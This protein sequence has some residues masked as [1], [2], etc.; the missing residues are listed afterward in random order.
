MQTN[1]VKPI[2]PEE[3]QILKNARQ[4]FL[5]TRS[6]FLRRAG[7]S[8]DAAIEKLQSNSVFDILIER[9]LSEIAY[10]DGPINA[11]EAN[12]LNVLLGKE[13]S[14]DYY[15]SL[16]R[17]PETRTFDATQSFAALI[18]L[19][20][21][22]GGV[23]QGA[24]YEAK[25]DPVV[26]CFEILGH[27]ILAADG[28]INQL[29]LDRLSKYTAI[30]HSK[31]AE[32]Y[33]RINS[34]TDE[35]TENLDPPKE[36]DKSVNAAD[37]IA[38]TSKTE[39]PENDTDSASDAVQK[40]IA[41]LHA[42][43]GLAAVKGEVETLTNL[44]KV[45]SIRKQRCLPVP[46]ISFHMVF[47]GNPGTGKT[48]VARIVAKIYGGLG[49]LSK[50]QLIEVDRSGLV[51]NFTG[52]TATKTKKVIDSAKGGVL[53]IDEAYALTKD[54]GT[55]N[56]FGPEA[57]E[58]IL[59]SMEDC[60]EDLVVIAAG[61]TDRMSTF[62][63]SNPGLR[64]RFPRVV[65]FP[66]YSVPEL[67]E[68]FRREA[69]RNQYRI[70]GGAMSALKEAVTGLWRSRGPDFANAREVRN[71][72]EHVVAMQANRISQSARITTGMLTTIMEADIRGCLLP[73]PRS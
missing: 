38:L 14:K 52:Q 68:I 70:D 24:A 45:F 53:F 35:V 46:D 13:T 49:L 43:V 59:K 8:D 62:L 22:L 33:Q 61:Y 34:P 25:T 11:R 72:F 60:R 9:V 4:Q 1:D 69:D 29:E 67:E 21:Q 44:A 64:S 48:T 71:L 5:D 10:A 12:A 63:G 39:I 66:D 6:D 15:N 17:R 30:A 2:S 54:S 31:A 73:A 7:E 27:A 19:A 57:I 23:E 32:L 18:N 26:G 50:G 47:S 36:S 28:D 56:D 51:A 58:V 16:L 55:S 37:N 3:L 20:I 41:E 40:C 65:T 42:L